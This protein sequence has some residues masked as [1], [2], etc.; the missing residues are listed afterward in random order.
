MTTSD[1]SDQLTQGDRSNTENVLCMFI[2]KA[3]FFPVVVMIMHST[4]L[5]IIAYWFENMWLLLYS[6]QE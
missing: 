4:R 2:D 3:P 6:T 1:R 5:H